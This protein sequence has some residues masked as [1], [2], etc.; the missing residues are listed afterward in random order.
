MAG[1]GSPFPV[2]LFP[3]P[4]FGAQCGGEGV[5]L[6]AGT[7]GRRTF[8][9][10]RSRRPPPSKWNRTHRGTICKRVNAFGHLL[11]IAVSHAGMR[12]NFSPLGV[13]TK[14]NKTVISKNVNCSTLLQLAYVVTCL[15][16]QSGVFDLKNELFGV[17]LHDLYNKMDKIGG[18]T[19]FQGF[20]KNRV[21][22]RRINC[23]NYKSLACLLP[24]ANCLESTI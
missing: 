15:V 22:K 4:L 18:K 10:R 23:V 3:R 21:A 20:V 6:G 8:A 24:Q 7:A 5:R 2:W 14:K 9:Q 12:F 13:I 1:S 16:L 17:L 11:N 19:K